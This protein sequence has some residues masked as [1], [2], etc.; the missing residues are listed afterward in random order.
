[1]QRDQ[2]PIK[3]PKH[4]VGVQDIK[5]GGGGEHLEW[6][7]FAQCQQPGD[8]VNIPVREDDRRNG[9]ATQTRWMQG[10]AI[11]KLAADIR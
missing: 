3:Y 6:G 11:V 1:M 10:S 2:L 5:P 8:M 7:L 9:A 4:A